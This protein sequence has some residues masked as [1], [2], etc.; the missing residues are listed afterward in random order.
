MGDKTGK[1]QRTI[2]DREHIK[3]VNEGSQG[4]SAV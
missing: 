1:G 2:E 3:T 4:G